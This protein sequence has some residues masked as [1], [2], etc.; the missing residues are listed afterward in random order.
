MYSKTLKKIF[1]F[2]NKNQIAK[3]TL[4]IVDNY[5]TN[6]SSKSIDDEETTLI[7]KS[8]TPYDSYSRVDLDMNDN[9][10]TDFQTLRIIQNEVENLTRRIEKKTNAFDLARRGSLYR[11]VGEIKLALDDMN[12]SIDIEPKFVDSYWQRHLIYLIQNRKQDALEDLNILLKINRH[13]SGAYISRYT[14]YLFLLQKIQVI[15]YNYV[16]LR[17]IFPSRE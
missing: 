6:F 15:L 17:I 16:C 13:H 10:V 2:H 1:R 12:R 4:I 3:N 11:K 9:T 8:P 14:F 7:R 5:L